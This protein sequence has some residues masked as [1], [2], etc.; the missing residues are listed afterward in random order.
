MHRHTTRNKGFQ[1]PNVGRPVQR[2]TKKLEYFVRWNPRQLPCH[3]PNGVPSRD[4]GT[5]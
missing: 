3:K 5:V 2:R 1:R 4:L